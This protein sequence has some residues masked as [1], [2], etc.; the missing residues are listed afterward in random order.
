MNA[1]LLS[2]GVACVIAAVVGGGLKAFNIEVPVI[3]SLGRQMLLFVIGLGFLVSAWVLREKT[4][5]PD[6]ATTA[7]RQLAVASCGRIVKIR[8]ADLP[9]DVIDL[10]PTGVRFHKAPLVRELR[11][12]RSGMQAELASLWTHEPPAGLRSQ[13]GLAEGVSAEWLR[14][15]D[16]RIRALQ[17]IA[18]DPVSQEDGAVLEQS[19]DAELRAR[20]NDA[21][22]AL[23]GQDCPIAG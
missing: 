16:E 2:A 19:G 4:S 14:R 10:S 1:V 8:T 12:R 20:V 13:H 7:Y 15:F 3:S 21:M 18:A 11:R 5:E 6:E 9:I 22:T 23:A 17:A